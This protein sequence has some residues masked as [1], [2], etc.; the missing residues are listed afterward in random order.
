[1]TLVVSP[2]Q[3]R[4]AAAVASAGTMLGG[5]AAGEAAAWLGAYGR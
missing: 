3:L 2:V 5:E 4:A 1:M